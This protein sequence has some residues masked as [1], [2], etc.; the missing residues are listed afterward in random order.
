MNEELE[1]CLD[2]IDH[3]NTMIDSY[4]DLLDLAGRDALGINDELMI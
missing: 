1:E 2:K 4:R 3:L